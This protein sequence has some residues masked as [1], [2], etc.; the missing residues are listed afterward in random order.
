MHLKSPNIF[1]GKTDGTSCKKQILKWNLVW[2]INSGMP[3][4]KAF[5][6]NKKDYLSFNCIKEDLQ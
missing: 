5:E 2:F 6:I 3:S 4:G 1:S